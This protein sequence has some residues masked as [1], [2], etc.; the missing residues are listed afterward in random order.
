MVA[1]NESSLFHFHRKKEIHETT[2]DLSKTEIIFGN[3]HDTNVKNLNHVLN[4]VYP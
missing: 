1:L 3:A 4:V 2:S